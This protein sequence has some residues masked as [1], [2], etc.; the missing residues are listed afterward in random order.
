MADTLANFDNVFAVI[1]LIF[2]FY[3]DDEIELT[4]YFSL[5]LLFINVIVQGIIHLI[6]DLKIKHAC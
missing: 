4:P 1:F 2:H 5:I 6:S 3:V